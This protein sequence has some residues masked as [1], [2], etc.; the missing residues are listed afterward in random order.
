MSATMRI[1]LVVAA[2]LLVSG[3]GRPEDAALRQLYGGEEGLRIVNSAATVEAYLIDP[4]G[5]DGVQEAMSAYTMREG[6]V[7][8]PGDVVG[9]LRGV[10][11]DWRS[12]EWEV[13]KAC[14]P[15]FGPRIRFADP[16]G[17]V[18]VLL[19]FT[20]DQLLIFRDGARVGQRDF[21]PIRSQLAEAVQRLF[22]EEPV[23]PRAPS[24]P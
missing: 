19:C 10:L 1:G 4:A 6:P 11:L 14:E 13:A 17:T 5:G 3:C 24:A 18:D 8:V 2:G 9:A 15:R 21:D 22:P 20:C 23:A 12:Y 16:A 7:L